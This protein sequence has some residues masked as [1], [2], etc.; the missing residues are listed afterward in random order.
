MRRTLVLLALGMAFV[1]CKQQCYIK[2]CDL[3]AY[4]AIGLTQEIECTAGTNIAPEA[5]CPPP[6]TVLQPDRPPKYV[7][8]AECISVA[9]EI[10]TVGNQNL[11]LNPRNVTGFPVSNDNLVGFTGT[12]VSGDD[13]I[14]VLSLDPAIQST[15]IEASL[16]KFDARWLSSMSWNNTDR[17]VG[18]ALDSFQAAGSGVAGI[19]LQDASFSTG[20]VKPLPTGGAAGITFRT[21][22]ELSNLNPRVNPAYRPALQF[23]FEQPLLQAFGVEIN[24]LRATHPGSIVNPFPTGGRVEGILITRI[25]FDQSR[26]ELERNI[27]FLL[28]NVEV[29]YWSLYGAYWNLYSR[30]QGLRQAYTAWRIAKARYEAG[31]IDISEFSQTRGQYES[32]RDQRISAMGDLLEA[33]R[34]L[35]KIMGLP[36]EDCTRLVPI[37]EPTLT[38]YVPDWCTALNEA[39]TL[40]PE[41]VLA[42][43]QVKFQQLDLIR[44]KN[45]LMPDLRFTS[46]YDINALGSRLDGP[47]GDG[48]LANLGAN[49]FHNWNFGLRLDVPIGFRDA[50]AA[51][52]SSRLSLARSYNLLRDQELKAQALLALNYRRIFETYENII[53]RRAAR[54]AYAQQLEAR[55][56]QFVAGRG[57]LDILLEAQRFW[58]DALSSEYSAIVNYNV[59]IAAF[60]FA[61]GTIMQFD[62]V[63]INEGPLPQCAQVRAAEHARARTHALVL[64]QRALPLQPVCFKN[65]GECDPL[66]KMIGVPEQYTTGIGTMSLPALPSDTAPSVPSL[67]KNATPLPNVNEALPR[68]RE[69]AVPPEARYVPGTSEPS[70]LEAIKDSMGPGALPPS[71][72]TAIPQ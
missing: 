28:A 5:T 40:R 45:L 53:A 4:R 12:G 16:S 61:K 49:K 14:R 33:E 55:F 6:S 72:Q 11:N 58:A 2:E 1:G 43:N 56:K 66:M 71:L 27:N 23:T 32:F 21:D 47:Q 36:V 60:Q 17:P 57:T 29:A 59:N 9:L 51:V 13:N 35:R 19:Q 67:Y 41:L 30:E 34:Q 20:L 42:R 3:D 38:P 68:P 31:R 24:Q 65:G 18:T 15:D 54:E 39:L 25:R 46:G 10:G 37:D 22:Y 69:S 64:A 52:R 7:T 50:H 63:V 8:L 70:A 62:N 44:Q 48:A 26:A